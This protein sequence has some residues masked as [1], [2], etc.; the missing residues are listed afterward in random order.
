MV[1]TA[2]LVVVTRQLAKA[3]GRQTEY[4]RQQTKIQKAIQRRT[5]DRDI[6]KVRMVSK[7]HSIGHLSADGT[8]ELKK[9]EGFTIT[10]A[11][12]IDVTITYAGPA[13]AVPASEPDTV[14]TWHGLRA[15]AE[16]YGV[17]IPNDRIPAKLQPGELITVLYDADD[18]VRIDRAFLLECQDS[19]GNTY[20][21]DYW[22]RVEPGRVVFQEGPG[23][24]YRAPTR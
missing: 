7:S 2:L 10:N 21:S 13:F 15:H 12:A 6:P 9:F 22:M 17:T 24:G 11:G 20:T 4:L 8:H 23:E 3:A 1:V 18:L 5:Q 19:L 14:R 16:W